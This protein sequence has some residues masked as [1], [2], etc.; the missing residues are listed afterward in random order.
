MN[1]RGDPHDRDSHALDAN[2][3]HDVGEHHDEQ[4]QKDNPHSAADP[5][6]DVIHEIAQQHKHD[7]LLKHERSKIPAYMI[8]ASSASGCSPDSASSREIKRSTHST[9]GS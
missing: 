7:Q 6:P 4:D 8:R 5:P 3:T 9:A 1:R 2:V